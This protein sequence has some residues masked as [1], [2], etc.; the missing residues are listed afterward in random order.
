MDFLSA[1]DSLLIGGTLNQVP[2]SQVWENIIIPDSKWFSVNETQT[3]KAFNYCFK[4]ID[5]V[6]SRAKNLMKI[7][8]NKFTLAKMVEKLDE[9]VTEKTSHMSTQ[10]GLQLPKL[11]KVDTPIEQPKIKLP[12]LKKMTSEATV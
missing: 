9:I 7:N 11:K 8:K 6:Q 5:E 4:N 12:K 3:Y 1:V 10:V 2:G